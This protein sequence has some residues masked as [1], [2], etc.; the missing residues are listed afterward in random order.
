MALLTLL[1]M[2][3][4]LQFGLVYGVLTY[5]GMCY[6]FTDDS[7]ACSWR[8]YIHDQFFW[9]SLLFIPLGIYIFPGWLALAGL[10]LARRGSAHPGEL[11]LPQVLL[12]P[13]TSCLGGFSQ[14]IFFPF[15]YP[16]ALLR[17]TYMKTTS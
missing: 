14:F 12:I 11:S 16:A 7:W 2:L 10:W 8:E 15:N 17:F 3:A 4:P 5:H 9:S 6:G 1:S 13:A